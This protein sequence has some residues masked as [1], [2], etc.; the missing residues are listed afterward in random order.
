LRTES[1]CPS[2]T[3]TE[4]PR[5]RQQRIAE[6]GRMFA[7][8][9]L[10]EQYELAREASVTALAGPRSAGGAAGDNSSGSIPA[11]PAG[12]RRP[13]QGAAADSRMRPSVQST[14]RRP[15]RRRGEGHHNFVTHHRTGRCGCVH[16]RLYYRTRRV[17]PALV[18][19]STNRNEFVSAGED[20]RLAR[21]LRERFS[22]ATLPVRP[23]SVPLPDQLRVQN[24]STQAAVPDWC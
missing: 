18:L 6:Y 15:F 9:H 22:V 2:G 4:A 20:L 11:P 12:A 10:V 5:P 16:N 21:P 23:L 19:H 3:C 13:V 17:E 1:Q 14:N 8:V 24:S 7:S